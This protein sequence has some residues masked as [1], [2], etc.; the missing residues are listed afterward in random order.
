M[1]NSPDGQYD[2]TKPYRQLAA[3][4]LGPFSSNEERLLSQALQ[5]ATIPGQELAEMVRPPFPQI[6]PF[7]PKMG[8]RTR[9]L[10]IE[11][12]IDIDRVYNERTD[13][14]GRDSSIQGTSRN[15]QGTGTW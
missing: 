2:R 8:Y 11:D 13:F 9:Q 3:P 15:T 14:S 12:I 10:G 6:D 7:R 4:Y 1:P 5:V